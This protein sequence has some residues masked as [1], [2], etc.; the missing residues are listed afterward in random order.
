MGGPLI[1]QGFEKWDKHPIKILLKV[2]RNTPSKGWRAELGQFPLLIWIQK[3]AIPTLPTPQSQ[4]AQL[5]PLQSPKM[6][7]M[8]RLSNHSL[9]EQPT[10][11]DM[12]EQ[13]GAAVSALSTQ[14][15]GDSR[16]TYTDIRTQPYTKITCIT[17]NFHKLS[18]QEKLHQLL[19]EKSATA[20][21]AAKYVSAST[22]EKK[23][24]TT[25]T[26]DMISSTWASCSWL[27]SHLHIDC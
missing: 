4:W 26:T 9:R 7:T 11:T 23:S 3:L 6:V 16:N 20:V 1:N 8:Y 19:G 2:C 21:D 22:G 18:D 12:A 17:P 25:T 13:R 14:T 5:L 10:Q 15:G 24:C 27:S